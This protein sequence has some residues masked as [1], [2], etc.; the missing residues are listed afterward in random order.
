MLNFIDHKFLVINSFLAN[1][2]HKKIL[3]RSPLVYA[4]SKGR[5]GEGL[6]SLFSGETSS[7]IKRIN[8]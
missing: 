5:Q 7:A 3:F 8:N 1:V 4:A 2:N 6:Y